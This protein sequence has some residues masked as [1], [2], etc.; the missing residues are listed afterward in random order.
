MGGR[1]CRRGRRHRHTRSI[2]VVTSKNPQEKPAPPGIHDGKPVLLRPVA[3]G[4]AARLAAFAR[5]LSFA[6]RYFR[7]GR[8]DIEFTEEEVRR[9]CNP[10]PAFAR[11]FIAVTEDEGHEIQI[12][13][14]RFQIQ[15]DRETCDLGILVADAWQG[16]RV[17]HRLLVKLIEA[18]KECHLRRM[19]ADVLATN[20]RMIR[21]AQRHGFVATT[22]E[23]ERP[24]IRRLALALR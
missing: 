1:R 4:D 12:G 11:H 15:D 21:F 24:G 7:F 16:T 17:A 20:I 19:T 13:S 8:D 9:L 6:T 18:A 2:T 10:D 23:D 3:P 5:G 22:E 14:A